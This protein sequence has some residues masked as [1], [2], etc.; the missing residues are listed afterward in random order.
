MATKNVKKETLKVDLNSTDKVSIPVELR[1]KKIFAVDDIEY[2]FDE[3]KFGNRD[4][5]EKYFEEKI[6]PFVLGKIIQ[7]KMNI[8]D[9]F[10]FS[11]R[12]QEAGVWQIKLLGRKYFVDIEEKM[13]D[14]KYLDIEVYLDDWYF[15]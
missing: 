10:Y 4:K 12:E 1:V 5:L 9:S 7:Y 15:D 13:V 8:G 3:N 14:E 6:K 2:D 11:E